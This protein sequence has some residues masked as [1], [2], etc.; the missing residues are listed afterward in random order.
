V[1][2]VAAHPHVSGRTP[3]QTDFTGDCCLVL[4]SEGHGLSPAVLAVCDEAAAIPMARN[5]DSLNVGNAA[6]VF[7]YEASRQRGATH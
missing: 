4:G 7:L 1:R 2:C 5:V 6:A 3:A